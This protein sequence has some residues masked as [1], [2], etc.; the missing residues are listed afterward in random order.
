MTFG[1]LSSYA[2]LE[3]EIPVIAD[4]LHRSCT[5]KHSL[6][7]WNLSSILPRASYNHLV[8]DCRHPNAGEI[9]VQPMPFSSPSHFAR[10]FRCVASGDKLFPFT[11]GF[12]RAKNRARRRGGLKPPS[13]HLRDPDPPSSCSQEFESPDKVSALRAQGNFLFQ[14]CVPKS[15][16]R[17]VPRAEEIF[18]PRCQEGGGPGP[19][20]ILR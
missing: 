6:P 1:P 7:R 12:M 4:A 3:I 15:K 20:L 14:R 18:L 9:Q 10:G 13:W 5:S 2:K 19:Y 8:P 17:F 11:Q 16:N